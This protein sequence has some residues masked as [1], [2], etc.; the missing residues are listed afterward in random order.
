MYYPGEEA[1]DLLRFYREWGEQL[2]DDLFATV[3]L[4]TAP[5]MPFLPEEMQGR[6]VAMLIACFIG[7]VDRGEERFVSC[8]PLR[9]PEPT[10]SG[11]SRTSSCSR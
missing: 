1:G 11:R 4:A 8:A 9:L 5:Q 6:P 10:R 2:P 7:P 3:N